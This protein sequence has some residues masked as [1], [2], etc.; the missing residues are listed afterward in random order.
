[1][2]AIMQLIVE[3]GRERAN[4][5]E[6]M[7]GALKAE[8]FE[9]MWAHA[10]LL[11]S[12]QALQQRTAA[13]AAANAAAHFTSAVSA[14]TATAAT[15]EKLT[16]RQQQQ[17]Q[18]RKRRSTSPL[19]AS[20]TAFFAAVQSSAAAALLS[21]S[22]A[23]V[24]RLLLADRCPAFFSNSSASSSTNSSNCSSTT[25]ALPHCSGSG[26]LDAA[27]Q[28]R[29]LQGSTVLDELPLRVLYEQSTA[30]PADAVYIVLSGAV[31]LLVL[32]EQ[33]QCTGQHRLTAARQRTLC[34]R[35][36][37]GAPVDTDRPPS[38]ECTT[39]ST[40][41]AAVT[42]SAATVTATT[43]EPTAAAVLSSSS[44]TTA[45][46]RRV[47]AEEQPHSSSGAG[48]CTG[49]GAGNNAA[50]DTVTASAQTARAA[51]APAVHTA[52]ESGSSAVYTGWRPRWRACRLGPGEVFGDNISYSFTATP[53]PVTT[54]AASATSAAGTAAAAI[55]LVS[56]L[57]SCRV[58]S[59][60]SDDSTNSRRNSAARKP[61]ATAAPAAALAD[62][63]LR[64]SSGCSR[65][66][67]AAAAATTAAVDRR[68]VTVHAVR[69][70]TAVTAARCEVLRVPLQ[71][72]TA[73]LKD[74]V[75]QERARRRSVLAA[76]FGAV[77]HSLLDKVSTV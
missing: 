4:S 50:T 30:A 61:S 10:K 21:P 43:A 52:Q 60:A 36:A 26:S 76:V 42:A 66:A 25:A 45:A 12:M 64:S 75:V 48:V 53:A 65:L 70:D 27:A 2:H 77:P 40:A 63:A 73:V 6:A 34:E 58:H 71:L 5:V 13:A 59:D 11:L 1:M 62:T 20:A 24:C 35:A 19:R 72:Y 7:Y 23:H 69:C 32:E 47:L 29:L 33:Q 74:A 17:E 31:D 54:R 55:T 49:G 67:R 3:H 22:Q 56:E 18:Q 41:A 37:R 14:A 15:A 51:A 8:H 28:I 9:Q 46:Q 68:S 16:P 39:A 57:R 44:S 38:P